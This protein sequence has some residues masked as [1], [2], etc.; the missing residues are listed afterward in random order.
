MSAVSFAIDTSGGAM[1]PA[2]DVVVLKDRLEIFPDKP[3]PELAT[4][5]AIAFAARDPMGASEQVYALIVSDVLPCREAALGRLS[6]TRTRGLF[7]FIEYGTVDWID[8]RRRLALVFER[9]A[10]PALA[11]DLSTLKPMRFND[12]VD[13]LLSPAVDALGNLALLGLT[14]RAIRPSNIFPRVGARELAFGDF[15]SGPAAAAQPVI[16][17][18]IES[19]M[20]LPAGRGTGNAG[21][22][23]F[24]LGVTLLLLYLGRNPV[25]HLSETELMASR[26]AH[27]SFVTLTGSEPLIGIVRD[28]LRGMLHDDPHQRWT[29]DDLRNW[30]RE[31]RGRIFIAT[32]PERALRAFSF[33]GQNFYACRPLAAQ[34]AAKWRTLSLADKKSDLVTWLTRSVQETFYINSIASAFDW[35]WAMSKRSIPG[36][37]DI[38]VN[39]RICAALD[40]RAPIRYKSFSAFIDGVGPAIV[41]SLGE[42]ERLREIAEMMVQQLPLFVLDLSLTE[43]DGEGES[44]NQMFQRLGHAFLDNRPGQGAERALYE[45]NPLYPCQSPVL[46]GERV[47]DIV[48]LLPALERV[49]VERPQGLPIDRHV[50]AFVAA[51]FMFVPDEVYTMLAQP[52]GSPT[53]AFGMVCMIAALQTKLGPRALP[54]L[55]HWMAPALSPLIGSFHR[56]TMRQRLQ[57][58]LPAILD[59]GDF[60]KLQEFLVNA[61]QRRRDRD[62]FQAAVREYVKLDSEIAFIE[63][64]G[65]SSPQHARE[66][67]HMMAAWLS[68]V[69][70]LA[71]VVTIVSFGI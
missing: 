27:G 57:S 44:I 58:S 69:V 49:A 18:T 65:A 28:L 15:L 20:C 71:A 5:W 46:A 62:E 53:H 39:A 64:G 30:L 36:G 31:R 12:L 38:G 6:G 63:S 7:D 50:A 13:R 8:G 23:I 34:L 10:G 24:S 37:M 56:L 22:D 45:L 21:N 26:I 33:G 41:A 68:L 66:Y 59:S 4:P 52:T 47:T 51:H 19:A 25:A 29:I 32:N 2:S 9:P 35:R 17:E 1:A 40:R 11:S 54:R 42:S 14:H 67:G 16:F 60:A 70:G 3:I 61:E 55:A 48:D 43:K